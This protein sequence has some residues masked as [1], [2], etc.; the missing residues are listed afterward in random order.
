[1]IPMP[2]F[3]ASAWPNWIDVIVITIFLKTCYNGFARGLLTELLNLLSA[4]IITALSINYAGV[5]T[6]WFQSWMA[7]PTYVTALLGFWVLFFGLLVAVHVLIRQI[8]RVMSWER[9]SWLVQ[10]LGLLLG[11]IRGL[12]WAGFLLVVL[13]AS[14]FAFLHESV[15]KNSVLGPQLLD[16]AHRSLEEVTARFPGTHERTTLVPPW[17]PQSQ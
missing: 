3:A 15:E 11:G 13:S 14:G 2:A 8:T 1:M 9:V 5:V 4:A 6:S 10:G 16:V 17:K 12:W 7:L